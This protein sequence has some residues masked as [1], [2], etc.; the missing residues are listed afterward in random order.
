VTDEP[1][2]PGSESTLPYPDQVET[3]DVLGAKARAARDAA[4]APAELPEAPLRA[5]LG[6]YQL[7]ELV[8]RG[9]MGVVCGAWDPELERRVAIKLTGRTSPAARERMLREGQVLARLSHPN[10]VPVYDAGEVGD[11]VYLVMEWV[12]GTTLRAFAEDASR[13]ALLDAY[14]QAGRGLAAAHREGVIHRDFKPDNA[15]RGEDERVRVLDFGLAL[16]GE[17]E[18][19]AMLAGTPRYMAPE[20]TRGEPATAASDQFAFCAS[21]REALGSRA[22]ELPRWIAAIVERGTADDPARRFASMADLL[23]ALDRDPGRRL[24][25][26]AAGAAVIA[27]TVA[28]FAIGSARTAAAVDTPCDRPEAELDA[29]W[30]PRLRDAAVERLGALGAPVTVVEIDGAVR[31]LDGYARAWTIGLTAAC[32]SDDRRLAPALAEARFAC[33]ARARSQLGATGELLAAATTPDAFAK[34]VRSIGALPAVEHCAH[35]APIEPPPRAIAERVAAIDDVVSRALTRLAAGY[36]DVAPAIDGAVEQAAG[37]GYAPL[38]ARA[39]LVQGRTAILLRDR[40]AYGALDRAWRLALAASDDA[41]AVEAYARWLF[42]AVRFGDAD[43]PPAPVSEDERTAREMWPVMRALAERL[44]A[45]GS[46]ALALLYNNVALGDMTTDNLDRARALFE[47]ARAAAGD[48]PALELIAVHENLARIAPDSASCE[49]QLRHALALR[50]AAPGSNRPDVLVARRNVALVTRG[51]EAREAMASA[52]EGLRAW[53]EVI[54]VRNCT[55]ELGWLADGDGDVDAA[56]TW[57]AEA[58]ALPDELGK[59]AAAY[60]AVVSAAPER[61]AVLDDMRRLA[62]PAAP[63][64]LARVIAADALVVLARAAERDAAPAA[65]VARLWQRVVEVIEPVQFAHFGRRKARAQRELAE[66]M[67]SS[68][69]DEAAAHATRALTWYRGAAGYE[70][71]VRRLERIAR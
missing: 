64:G 21:L 18:P 61:A 46:F 58:A 54:A 48:R 50:E 32:R 20:Q 38:N 57:M 69:A 70:D 13:R 3:V 23:A 45:R 22:G 9:G 59:I 65:D 47:R 15:I 5:T 19:A 11:Q 14:R 36:R 53:G 2:R 26:A 25:W 1:H 17:A 62:Q 49:R 31:A 60:V 39:L 40:R 42:V 4:T 29:A 68:N 24:R 12:R 56:R 55:F 51:R 10:V 44:G 7:L 16:T 6:R 37:T 28:A 63:S 27:A 66:R 67:A 71:V 35:A 41:L 30:S 52:C 43:G 8:G 33:L 34:A